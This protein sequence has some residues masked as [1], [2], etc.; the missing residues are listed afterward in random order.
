MRSLFVAASGGARL[1]GWV[2][3]D[4]LPVLLLHGGPGLSFTYMDGLAEQLTGYRV[5]SYQ[6]RGLPPSTTHGPFAVS[7]HARDALAVLDTL[8]WDRA[9]VVGHSWGGHLALHLAVAAA[10]RLLGVLAVDTLG[11]VGDGGGAEFG[12]ELAR[13]TPDE[14]LTRVA[15]LDAKVGSGEGTEEDEIEWMRLL[16]PA[17]FARREDAPPMP[18]ISLGFECYAETCGSMNER[19]AQLEASLPEIAVPV[20]FLSG[21]RSPMPQTASID[22]AARIPGAWAEAVPDAGH[23]PWIDNP[24]C[25]GPSLAR[26]AGS[27]G[28]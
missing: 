23:F 26:L 2:S 18:R 19:M 22:T 28:G 11:G 10:D 24:G 20:G 5:A 14:D 16:W 4:G 12:A 17:Y 7:D 8:G 3:G 21:A 25:V 1:E 27:A 15:R 13:R 9:L 6:Q